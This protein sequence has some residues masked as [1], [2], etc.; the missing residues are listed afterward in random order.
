MIVSLLLISH[1][2]NLLLR[3]V[4]CLTAQN[5]PLTYLCTLRVCFACLSTPHHAL[6]VLNTLNGKIRNSK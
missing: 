1:F 6:D 5:R 4:F 2:K 3:K